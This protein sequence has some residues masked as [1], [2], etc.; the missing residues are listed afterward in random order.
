M[1]ELERKNGLVGG[2][3]G[4]LPEVG[5]LHG[6]AMLRDPLVNTVLEQLTHLI[7]E[8]VDQVTRNTCFRHSRI[9]LAISNYRALVQSY[10]VALYKSYRYRLR[11]HR[12]VRRV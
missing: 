6:I 2:D 11:L 3:V 7:V 1:N 12:F 10:L 9:V 8:R 4:V 5:A